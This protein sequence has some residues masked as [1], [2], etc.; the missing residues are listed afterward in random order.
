MT[1][2]LTTFALLC[3]SS[4]LAIIN[5]L[6]AAPMYRALTEGYTGKHRRRT[7][8]TAMLTAFTVLVIFGRR[9]GSAGRRSTRRS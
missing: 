3:F 8:R 1:N 9:G 4:L 6:S 5:P 2:E 7:L